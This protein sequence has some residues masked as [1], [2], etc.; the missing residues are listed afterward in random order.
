MIKHDLDSCIT[1][2][3]IAE[4]KDILFHPDI[5]KDKNS[6]YNKIFWG[7]FIGYLTN[8]TGN[9]VIQKQKE[10]FL[11][12]CLDADDFLSS[13]NHKTLEWKLFCRFIDDFLKYAT[14]QTLDYSKYLSILDNIVKIPDLYQYHMN[15]DDVDTEIICA[16]LCKMV[17][18]NSMSDPDTLQEA[19]AI[20]AS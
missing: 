20:I 10:I 7:N 4:W 17:D 12:Y 9:N 15:K 3:I 18:D 14:R 6:V 8:L 5:L 13:C 1:E 2:E 16:M 19:Y 11:D